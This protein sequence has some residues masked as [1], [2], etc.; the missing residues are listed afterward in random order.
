MGFVGNSIVNET[1]NVN[2]T[3]IVFGLPEPVVTWSRLDIGII[4]RSNVEFLPE[5][6]H[7]QAQDGGTELLPSPQLDP[8]SNDPKFVTYS[9]SEQVPGGGMEVRSTL[10]INTLNGSDTGNYTCMAANRPLGPQMPSISS[11]AAF[12]IVVQSKIPSISTVLDIQYLLSF[13]KQLSFSSNPS[14][15]AFHQYFGNW[16]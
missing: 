9:S 2:V 8:G 4:N 1:Q 3:C 12:R 5:P 10:Q 15:A 14:S 11:S 7:T 13:D 6:S 16:G